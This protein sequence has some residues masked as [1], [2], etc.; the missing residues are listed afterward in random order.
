MLVFSF[1]SKISKMGTEILEIYLEIF[2]K[3]GICKLTKNEI[4]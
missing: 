4:C 3:L 1:K 2:Q